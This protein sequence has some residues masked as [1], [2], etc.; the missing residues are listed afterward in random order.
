MTAKSADAEKPGAPDSCD[1]KRLPL[2]AY[3]ISPLD[4][5]LMVAP[6]G[7]DWMTATP[8]HFANRCLPL[9]IAN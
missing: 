1:N 4:M 6:A 2:I 7:G 5:P 3:P 9:L 8:Q